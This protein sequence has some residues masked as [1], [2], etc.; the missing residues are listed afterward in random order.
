MYQPIHL[1]Y[2]PQTLTQIIGQ[3]TTTTTLQNAVTQKRIAPVYLF[4]GSRGTGKTS[5]ARIL[6][7]MINCQSKTVPCNECQSCTA[8]NK[9]N[10]LDVLEID[11]ASNSGV[12]AMRGVIERTQF[13]PVAGKWKII[14]IDECHSLSSQA[15]Q[16]LLKTTEHPPEHVCFI[17]CTTEADK[18]PPTIVSRSQ[19]FE[20]KLII[21][22][23]IAQTLLSIASE[24]DIDLSFDG[25]I[26]IANV[27]NGHMR[28][29]QALLDQ[30]RNLNTQITEDIVNQVC[31]VVN[32]QIALKILAYLGTVDVSTAIEIVKDLI[33][34]GKDISK[35][36][37]ALVTTTNKAIVSNNHPIKII[38]NDEE[39]QQIVRTF[40][41]RKHLIKDEF[42]EMWLEAILIEIART[43]LD[44]RFLV[45]YESWDSV[46][47]ALTWGKTEMPRMDIE[48]AWQNIVPIEGK[49]TPG[50]INFILREKVLSLL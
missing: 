13:A 15:W 26:A 28:D 34:R 22:Q 16:S 20:F 11:A 33:N 2:R 48:A 23:T 29:A 12:E 7:K 14:I 19:S 42:G 10:Y 1:K 39:L 45:V 9:G 3:E 6:A 5:T 21:N 4:I 46:E 37:N 49:K 18:V 50:W 43:Q 38:W 41:G 44:D 27:K 40:N 30:L 17:F 47:D 36:L 8:I 32:E 31:G 35:I 24:E 25:A